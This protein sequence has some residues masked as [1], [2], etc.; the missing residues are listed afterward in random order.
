[1][2][3]RRRSLHRWSWGLAA[4]ALVSAGIFLKWRLASASAN[5]ATTAWTAVPRPVRAA[6][7]ADARRI[8][9][10]AADATVP[11]A[12]AAPAGLTEDQWQTLQQRV[13]PGPQHDRELAR[14]VD[15]LEFQ[16]RVVALRESR[17]DADAAAR[18]RLLATQIES[19]IAT[20]LALREISGPEAMLL[21]AA[22]L[23]EMEPDP[24]RR[25]QRLA[26]WGR[27]WTNEHPPENDPRVAEYQRRE[28]A[29]VAAWQSGPVS[30]RD[31]AQLARRLQQL[32]S[33]VFDPQP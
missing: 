9:S 29:A 30:Q 11:A 33:A 6:S 19:G 1:M 25:A 13:E 17:G 18:R 5:E 28:A 14:I 7:A 3:N 21:E 12:G 15:F 22:S 2:P 31:P 27:N 20:H 16:R 24:A 8:P 23:D 4:V 10:R 32:Q 26:D